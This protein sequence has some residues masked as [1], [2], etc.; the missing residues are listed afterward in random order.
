MRLFAA[1][2][3]KR[4]QVTAPLMAVAGNEADDLDAHV[5]QAR[6][7]RRRE[8]SDKKLIEF[9]E[10]TDEMTDKFGSRHDRIFR[11]TGS[12]EDLKNKNIFLH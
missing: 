9:A 8:L 12:G 3:N 11:N 4:I 6:H 2:S 10:R 1:L 5:R 7:A